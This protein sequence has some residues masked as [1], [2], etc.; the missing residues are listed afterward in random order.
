M[1][2]YVGFAKGKSVEVHAVDLYR[3]KIKAHEALK[4]AGV[5]CNRYEVAV[6]LAEKDGEPVVHNPAIL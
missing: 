1:N 3:A 4:A 5:R 6:V 2:G